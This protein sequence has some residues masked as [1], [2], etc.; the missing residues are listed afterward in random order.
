MCSPQAARVALVAAAASPMIA[1]RLPTAS[2][3]TRAVAS[4]RR[5]RRPTP[6]RPICIVRGR[7]RTRRRSRSPASWL[8]TAEPVD[9]SAS[10]RSTRVPRRIAGSAARAG[11][12]TP[13]RAA[14]ADHGQVDAEADV[15]C[16]EG[17]AEER[18]EQ[19]REQDAE[20]DSHQ[21]AHGAEQ[22]RRLQVHE[23][24]LPAAGADRPHDPDLTRLLGDERRHRVGDQDQR[25]EER[26]QRDHAEEVDEQC[27][28]PPCPASHPARGPRAGPRSP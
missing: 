6:R 13:I 3:T 9:S 14:T 20:R 2:A 8:P 11:P 10:R 1:S 27:R 21:R 26:E 15:D 24:D 28:R 19:I 25:R 7:K 22:Q 17:R 23:S 18:G 12:S 16:E 4:V 5:L